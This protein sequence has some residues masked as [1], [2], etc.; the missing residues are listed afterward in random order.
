MRALLSDPSAVHIMVDDGD[1][2]LVAA[3]S[4][5]LDLDGSTIADHVF[6]IARG[7]VED[8]RYSLGEALWRCGLPHGSQ[9]D[10]YDTVFQ[11]VTKVAQAGRR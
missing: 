6:M 1:E 10:S 8:R 7:N 4:K 11:V 9:S 5:Q 2:S 3:V